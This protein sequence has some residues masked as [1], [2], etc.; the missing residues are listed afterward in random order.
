MSEARRIQVVVAYDFSPSSE[1]ALARAIEVAMRAPQYTLHIVAVIDPHDPLRSVTYNTADQL[2]QAISE[3]VTA[4]F[5]RRDSAGD[6]QFFVHARIGKPATEI[7]DFAS[8]FGADLIFIGSHGRT[9]IARLF[10]GSVSERVVREA[11][12]PV[13]VARAKTYADVELLDVFRYD[14][15]HKRHHEPH[16]YTYTSNQVILRPTDWPLL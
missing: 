9:G 10:L 15:A 11:L 16:C 1:L 2:Q 6:I 14:H 7:L 12:C 3:R 4:A 5:A 8:D 13:F